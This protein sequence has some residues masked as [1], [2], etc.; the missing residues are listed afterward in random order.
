MQGEFEGSVPA[1]HADTVVGAHV[2]H[3]HAA[4][5]KSVFG[6]LCIGYGFRFVGV[7]LGLFQKFVGCVVDGDAV[8]KVC[9]LQGD[10]LFLVGVLFPCDEW[11]F[12]LHKLAKKCDLY[13]SKMQFCASSFRKIRFRHV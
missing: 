6:C 1:Q 8:G 9:F 12:V 4:Q 11:C 10:E 3:D 7:C 2:L 5:F 13:D